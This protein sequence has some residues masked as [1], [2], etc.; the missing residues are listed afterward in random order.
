MQVALDI[1]YYLRRP[2]E[3]LLLCLT[4]IKKDT[5]SLLANKGKGL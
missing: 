1:V 5:L 2:G 4:G 3:G